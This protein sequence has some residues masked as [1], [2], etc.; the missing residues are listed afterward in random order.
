[1]S[2]PRIS[3]DTL[4]YLSQLKLLNMLNL[5]IPRDVKGYEGRRFP[6]ISVLSPVH[7]K[8]LIGPLVGWMDG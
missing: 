8:A 1:M 5:S 6:R 4:R 3:P 7:N 2:I